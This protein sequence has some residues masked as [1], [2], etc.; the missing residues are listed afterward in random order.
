[1]TLVIRN[2]HVIDPASG[3]SSKRDIL[4]SEGVVREIGTGLSGDETVDAE[5]L[6]VSPGFVELHAHFREP[7]FESKETIASGARSAAHGGYT[8]VVTMANTDPCIDN[9]GMVEFV[10]RRARETAAVRIRPA[11]SATKRMAGQEITEMAELRV[12][13]A[14]AVTDNGAPIERSWVMRRALEYARMVNLP[15]LAHCEDTTLAE[16]GH[17]NE[18]RVATRLGLPGLPREMEEIMIERNCRLA[19]LTGARLH[20]QH[21]S[22]RGGVDIIRRF[23]E[24]G[25][26][27]TAEVTPHHLTLTDEALLGFDTNMKVNP[28]LREPED[29]AALRVALAD[30]TIDCVASCHAPHTPTEKDVEFALAPFGV[31]GMET[32]FA[33]LWTELVTPGLLTPERAIECL[34][35]APAKALG[36]AAGTLQEGAAADFTLIDPNAEWT[37]DPAKFASQSRNTPFAGRTFQGR[38]E[39]TYCRGQKIY[40]T[41]TSL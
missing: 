3:L 41:G 11:A 24:Q 17:I 10:N 13:G 21:V 39:A 30:G 4:I 22:T 1:M 6:L 34:T 5:G 14:V 20:V 23:K 12:V 33:A 18:G 40:G 9:A 27:I 26:Q 28:P 19:V 37:V 32:A 35:S 38:V 29:V 2:G 36:I 16:A 7:G 8:T 15:F 25:A 31:V